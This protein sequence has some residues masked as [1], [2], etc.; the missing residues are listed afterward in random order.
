MRGWTLIGACVIGVGVF[1]CVGDDPV[2][3]LAPPVDGGGLTPEA[4]G[5]SSSSSA[6]SSS[7]DGGGQ[8]TPD[9]S[10]G[11]DSS[12]SS[13]TGGPGT[14][15]LFLF[16]TSAEYVGDLGGIAGADARC[17]TAGSL[18]RPAG[19][20][21]AWLGAASRADMAPLLPAGRTWYASNGT[22]LLATTADLIGGGG[23]KNGGL[24]LDE[25]L[26]TVVEN[27]FLWT[28]VLASGTASAVNCEGWT[29]SVPSKYG[30]VATVA[31][32]GQ[33][34]TKDGDNE[35]ACSSANHLA[36]IEVLP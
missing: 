5:S 17:Q 22:T 18:L 32:P 11:A 15:G 25:K 20:F 4:G 12:A 33:A 29:T 30:A 2:T 24:V 13:T 10:S 26:A 27:D 6:S 8:G 23:L 31:T 21:I 19:K 16:L 9:G 3:P 7:G 35:S 1:A 28:A 14:P 36:C 34:W